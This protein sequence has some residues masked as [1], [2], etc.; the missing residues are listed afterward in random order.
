VINNYSHDGFPET[1]DYSSYESVSEE[2]AVPEVAKK[3][4]PRKVVP[5][6][7]NGSKKRRVMKNRTTTDA[8]GYTRTFVIP[9]R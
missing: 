9:K 1:E 5:V 7:R 2:D 6:G 4:K 8:K 3:R